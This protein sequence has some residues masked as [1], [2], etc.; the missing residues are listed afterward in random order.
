MSYE[1]TVNEDIVLDVSSREIDLIVLIQSF[2][3][4][5]TQLQSLPS[6]KSTPDAETLVLYNQWVDDQLRDTNSAISQLYLDVKPI[7]DAGLL[8]SK[9][10][11]EY[12]QL[13]NY[14]NNL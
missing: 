14:V 7:K 12:T 9:Y 10:D 13:E 5:K 1:A 6:Q 8:P 3:N 2:T 4:L 11:D